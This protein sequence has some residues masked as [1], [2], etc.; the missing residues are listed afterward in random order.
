MIFENENFAARAPSARAG[1]IAYFLGFNSK[2]FQPVFLGDQMGCINE[3]KNG[4][5]SH[6]TATLKG[7]CQENR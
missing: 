7:E 1:N 5:K 3:I 4:K 6:G 2:P